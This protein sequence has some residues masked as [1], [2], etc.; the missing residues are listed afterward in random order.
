MTN[1]NGSPV[2]GGDEFAA[3]VAGLGNGF[4]E[5]SPSPEDAMP[6]A[7]AVADDANGPVLS[8]DVLRREASASAEVE[9]RPARAIEHRDGE[10]R[11]RRRR[12]AARPIVPG[13]WKDPAAF[14]ATVK[15]AGGQAANTTGFHTVRLPLYCGRLLWRSPLGLWRVLAS[16]VSWVRDEANAAAREA[17]LGATSSGSDYL[18]VREDHHKR[19]RARAWCAGSGLAGLSGG[20]VALWA[21]TDPAWSIG[22]GAAALAGLGFAGSSKDKPVVNRADENAAEEVLTADLITLALAN[23]G[24]S[25]INRALGEAEKAAERAMARRHLRH[26]SEVARTARIARSRRDAI[27]ILALVRD[28]AGFRA[29]I[30]LPPGATA[31]EVCARREKI[32]GTLDRNVSQVWPEVAR[33]EAAN[34]LI[35]W[36]ADEIPSP[37]N[38]PAWPL[39]KAG[40]TNLFEAVPFGVDQRGRPVAV[41]LMFASGLIG[42]VPRMGKSFSLRVLALAAALDPRC[43]LHLYDFK[44]GADFRMF[45]AIAHQYRAGAKDDD[46][47]TL[48]AD[49][50]QL[51]TEMDRRY[52]VVNKLPEDICP[53]GKV[54]DKLA[55][56]KDLRLHPIFMGLD[57]CQVAYEH[58]EHGKWLAAAIT[59]LVKRGPAVGIMVWNAT[60]RVDAASIPRGISSNAVLRFCLMVTGQTEND[61]VLGTSRYK[62]GVNATAFTLSDKGVGWLVG[63]GDA[64][65]IVRTA[66]VDAATAKT[67]VARAKAA[68]IAAGYLSGVAAGEIQADDDT[69]SILDH[70]HAVWPKNEAGPLPKV[71]SEDLAPLLAAYKPDLY[72]GWKPEQVGDALRSR[73]I[74]TKQVNKPD[75]SGIRR[76]RRGPAYAD[77]TAALGIDVSTDE[78]KEENR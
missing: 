57:E 51:R 60:Q 38:T 10:A 42:A 65:T 46:I 35:L 64:P 58:D 30:K 27:K 13:W 53:E 54:T 16:T 34:R 11:P 18:M 3:I 63:E 20:G 72:E 61:M 43:E 12:A 1:G 69:T 39:L 45:E 78:S 14:V 59:D 75:A 67:I 56:R 4:G 71:W 36:V 7:D 17:V 22:A 62:S 33:G 68:K 9:E 55:S 32:A 70:V 6:G 76:T 52:A 29:D 44:G 31:A 74:E 37:A 8:G 5:V 77:I 26:E 23:I 15:W 49:V 21:F 19:V 2:S 24:H 40:A 66:Y 41:E 47:A 25:A 73:D 50:R 28:G 48:V